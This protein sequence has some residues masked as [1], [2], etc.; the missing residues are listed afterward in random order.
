MCANLRCN[1]GIFEIRSNAVHLQARQDGLN[2]FAALLRVPHGGVA[3]SSL[4]VAGKRAAVLYDSHLLRSGG[5]T[6][7]VL[8]PWSV[9][10]TGAT[11]VSQ[12][13]SEHWAAYRV[14]DPNHAIRQGAGQLLAVTDDRIAYRENGSVKI[15]RLLDGKAEAAFAVTPSG[16]KPVLRFLEGTRIWYRDSSH[17]AIRDLSG[18]TLRELPFQRVGV[19]D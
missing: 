9:S 7:V 12:Q 15:V 6:N 2:S 14:N 13:G 5:L 4:S 17:L 11:F 1:L 3:I 16:P 10:N 8:E 19:S 18:N